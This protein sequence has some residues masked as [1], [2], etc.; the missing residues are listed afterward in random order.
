[1]AILD[2]LANSYQV[3]RKRTEAAKLFQLAVKHGRA[4]TKGPRVLL[5][6]LQFLGNHYVGLGECLLAL[7]DR[8]GAEIA[9]REAVAIRGRLADGYP[10]IVELRHASSDISWHLGKL[11]HDTG[12]F[13]ESADVLL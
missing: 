11:L 10:G 2:T 5:P 12:R 7:G 4:S 8:K 13:P 6:H 3:R 9:W 1:G